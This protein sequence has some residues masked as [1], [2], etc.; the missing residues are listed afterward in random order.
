MR[1]ERREVLHTG[2][3]YYNTYNCGKCCKLF[4]AV[5]GD[6]DKITYCNH[7]RIAPFIFFRI[8]I[9][10]YTPTA[11]NYTRKVFIRMAADSECPVRTKTLFS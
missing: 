10:C 9:F 6:S 7:F 2:L 5:T 8:S 1:V 3:K 11:V 4:T